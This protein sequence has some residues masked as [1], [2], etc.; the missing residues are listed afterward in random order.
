MCSSDLK[1][2][3]PYEPEPSPQEELVV[4]KEPEIPEQ[5]DKVEVEV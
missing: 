1:T 3:P 4:P 2:L 5:I